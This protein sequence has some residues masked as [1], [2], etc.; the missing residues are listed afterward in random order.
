[1][2]ILFVLITAYEKKLSCTIRVRYG[3]GRVDTGHFGQR[4]VI[5]DISAVVYISPLADNLNFRKTKGGGSFLRSYKILQY[6][7]FQF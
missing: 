6:F 1:M 3:V 2:R 5:L 4:G 7:T